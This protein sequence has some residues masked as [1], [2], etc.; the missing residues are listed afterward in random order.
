VVRPDTAA[1]TSTRSD[2]S[3]WSDA[4]HRAAATAHENAS[5]VLARRRPERA[6]AHSDT[7]AW[8][9]ARIGARATA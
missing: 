5:A 3:A 1:M 8:L 9:R 7:A 6:R 2:A 4:A